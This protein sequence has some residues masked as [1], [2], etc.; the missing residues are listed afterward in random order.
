MSDS[1][2]WRLQNTRTNFTQSIGRW[3]SRTN[4]SRRKQTSTTNSQKRNGGLTVVQSPGTLCMTKQNSKTL[5]GVNGTAN[6][7]SRAALGGSV[8]QQQGT[9]GRH[10]VTACNL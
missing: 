3:S 1:L 8:S 4:P 5:N 7:S 9:I 6:S 2:V 10:P